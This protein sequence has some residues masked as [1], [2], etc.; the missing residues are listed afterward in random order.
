M[1]S[2]LIAAGQTAL[3]GQIAR[4]VTAAGFSVELAED[5]KRALEIVAGVEIE[6]VIVIP[7]TALAGVAQAL[8]DKVRRTIV[9]VEAIVQPDS[10]VEAEAYRWSD[11]DERGLLDQIRDTKALPKETDHATAPTA[12]VLSVDNCSF[13]PSS[14][15]FFDRNRRE[16]A[17]TRAET[18]LLTTLLASAGRTLSRDKL[19]RA[20]VGHGANPDDRSVDVLV[21]R[22]RRKIEP[23]PTAPRFVITFPGIGYRFAPRVE[24]Q[25]AK[26]AAL[27]SQSEQQAETR[28]SVPDRSRPE[29]PT[30][31]ASGQADALPLSEIHRRQLTVLSCGLVVSTTLASI[32][33]AEQL[34][35][36]LRNFQKLCADVITRW[37]GTVTSSTM[38]E[39]LALFG[40]PKGHEDD[41]ERAVHAGLELVTNVGEIQS[42]ANQDLQVRIGI[43]TGLVLISE[44]QAAVG[45]ALIAAA[46]LQHITPPNTVMVGPRTRKL[47]GD[48]FACEEVGSCELERNSEPETA[49]RITGK[50]VFESRFAAK[51]AGKLTQLV[52]RQYELQQLA[53]LWE[54][55]KGGK[56]HVAL[57][58]GEAGI[59]KSRLCQSFIDRINDEPHVTIPYQCSPYHSNSPFFPVIR[60]LEQTA[61]FE[62]EDTPDQKL[63]KLE[64][65]LAKARAVTLGDIPLFTTLLSIP[66]G[67]FYAV[68]DMTPQRRRDL[69]I[70]VL[71]R[72]ILAFAN[73][74][75]VVILLEDVH[76]IDSSTLELFNRCID[77]IKTVR[78]FALVS[79]R[80]EF[81][82]HWLEASHV[83]M[84][85][86][87][88]LG[89]E[90]TGAIISDV[91]EH[92]PLPREVYEEI[93]AKSDGVPLFAE[94]LTKAVL[95]SDQL[96]KRGGHFVT[97]RKSVPLTVPTTLLGSLTARLD[98][99]GPAKEIAQVGAAIGREFSHRLLAAVA[100]VPSPGLEAAL[101]QLVALEMIFIRGEASDPIYTFK[102]ALVRDAAYDTMVRSK[103]QELHGRI[104]HSLID[105]FRETIEEQPELVAHHLAQAGV[106]ERAIPYL[107]VAGRR[108][109]ERSANTEAIGHLTHGLALLE[110]LSESPERNKMALALEVAVAQAMIASFGY[111]APTTRHALLRA[112]T[113]IDQFADPSQTFAILY[114]LWA[115]HY[116][117]GEAAAQ[118][119]AALAFVAEAERHD[120][121]AAKCI[122][123][124][125]LGTTFL[126][127]GEFAAGLPHLE[128]ARALYHAER[129]ATYRNQYGQDIGVAALCYQAWALW[130]LGYV[131]QAEAIAAEAMRDA[132][133][134]S[135]PHTTVYAICHARGF[136]DIFRRSCDGMESYASRAVSLSIENKF[137]HWL[138]CAR[139]L[140]GWAAIN[141]G[142]L[143]HGLQTLQA[144]IAGWQEGGARLWLPFFLMLEA[145]GYSRA[146]RADA[147]LKATEQA[148][149]VCKEIS[150]RW[151][152]AELLRVK[153]RLLQAIGRAK[154]S[155]IEGILLDSLE[156]ARAQQARSW[157]LR[158]SCDLARLWQSQREPRKGLKLLQ[159]IY[160]QFTEGFDT[161]DLL[162]A[163]ALLESL[164]QAARKKIQ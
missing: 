13:D 149:A 96:Q 160:D 117:G 83:T 53:T 95:D 21:G 35:E 134:L 64:A 5:G 79:F 120:D 39:A 84:L 161:A 28:E 143:D 94:E 111:A 144:G 71:I 104:A 98:G 37:G 135:H 115:S 138:N 25:R 125:S 141:Q 40:H 108:A 127:M 30:A 46:R 139:I 34:G 8:C 76:W 103:R 89:R 85:Q 150:E 27:T 92:Q 153:A 116:V 72:Q 41:A 52:G 151:A 87:Q 145:E 86:L 62:Q 50:Q 4:A 7:E 113:R 17:L 23:N 3:R 18:S 157:E 65:E 68:P 124:R 152:M 9:L 80:P 22:L 155:E 137:S 38:D 10:V 114:G 32:L 129:H 154:A 91:A 107:Q 123:H 100:R 42:V 163:K 67:G 112:K 75:P 148:L 59:G 159:A 45:G 142:D 78:V 14:R 97:V 132:D 133:E 140:Q 31:S 162:E 146:N 90:Q 1:G 51:R 36:V 156:V 58:C 24:I 70:A 99:L 11:F 26:G 88:R 66:T 102:H 29:A 101:S 48:V 93:I 43:A 106:T 33:D 147:A 131:D 55:A 20:V 15:T 69:T 6:T 19:R 158:T 73:I 105:Q 82:P 60:Q 63:R 16:V 126:A 109:I 74:R 122:A 56:G 49:Y 47:L 130:L 61:K 121:T 12:V 119:D 136:I 110:T 2:V 44:N 54:L 118:K 77:A 164:K 128:R 57:V 81:F